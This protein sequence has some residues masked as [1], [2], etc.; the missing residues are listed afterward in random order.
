MHSS[1]TKGVIVNDARFREAHGFV[2]AKIISDGEL[3]IG[4]QRYITDQTHITNYSIAM[5][6]IKEEFVN[7]QGNAFTLF[8]NIINCLIVGNAWK[9]GVVI[10]D[11]NNGL[12]ENQNDG[13]FGLDENQD[14]G[15]ASVPYVKELE[16][17]RSK[18]VEP[19]TIIIFG[20]NELHT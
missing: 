6:N 9:I 4:I 18:Y 3:I 13:R 7:I 10:T 16:N 1:F 20:I 12:D 15:K 17:L 19:Q 11:I 14:L 8:E 2:H 5:D